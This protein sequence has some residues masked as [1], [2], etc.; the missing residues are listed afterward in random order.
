M[1]FHEIQFNGIRLTA[2]IDTYMQGEQ[3]AMMAEGS[4]AC[5]T[6]LPEKQLMGQTRNAY[7]EQVPKHTPEPGIRR[8]NC[9]HREYSGYSL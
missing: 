7:Q 3:P 6:A 9:R 2:N 5:T 8:R 4:T 1:R